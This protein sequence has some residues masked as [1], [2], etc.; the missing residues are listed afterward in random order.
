[1]TREHVVSV[2]LALIVVEAVLIS[3]MAW[4]YA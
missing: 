4:T 2:L 1:M 3:T